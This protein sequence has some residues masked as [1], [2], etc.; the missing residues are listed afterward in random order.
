MA[1]EMIPS[2][3]RRR[4]RDGR[5]LAFQTGRIPDR[6]VAARASVRDR[7][8]AAGSRDRHEN[9]RVTGMGTLGVGSPKEGLP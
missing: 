1:R 9:L 8:L 6:H 5:S 3:R 2:E 4:D 7:H